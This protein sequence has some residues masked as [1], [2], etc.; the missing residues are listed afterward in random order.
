MVADVR[1]SMRITRLLVVIAL[2]TGLTVGLAASP[3]AACSCIEPDDEQSFEFADAVFTGEVI[4][5]R[6]DADAWVFFVRVDDVF[7]GEVTEWQRL[8]SP[9]QSA[10]CGIVLPMDTTVVVF[11]YASLEDDHYSVGLCDPN[12][13]IDATDALFPGV[14]PYPPEPGGQLPDSLTPVD[15]PEPIEETAA[16][17]DEEVVDEPESA[18]SEQDQAEMEAQAEFEA[19]GGGAT[20]LDGPASDD[21]DDGTSALVW[22]VVVLALAVVG[23]TV[24]L[25]RTRRTV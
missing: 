18:L 14:E 5:I 19:T 24:A 8:T 17:P 23:L 20:L 25:V 3:A 10:E 1:S 6:E 15:A 9:L 22:V 13:A 12:R 7:K 21:P 16:P 4:E 2:A 11:G